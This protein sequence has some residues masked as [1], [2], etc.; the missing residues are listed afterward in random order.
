MRGQSTTASLT[1]RLTAIAAG[2]AQDGVECREYMLLNYL[3]GRAP[4]T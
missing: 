3:L 1:L 2:P 4:A